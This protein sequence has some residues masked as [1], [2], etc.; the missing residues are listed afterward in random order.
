M[1]TTVFWG[2]LLS[3]LVEIERCVNCT[4][5]PRRLSSSYSLQPESEISHTNLLCNLIN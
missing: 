3:S 5:Y 1:K 2:I 4:Q